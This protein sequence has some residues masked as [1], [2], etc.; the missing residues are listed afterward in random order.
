V[1]NEQL[2][3]HEVFGD[4]TEGSLVVL[5]RKAG[6]AEDVLREEYIET[7]ELP[8]DSDRKRM[9]VIVRNSRNKKIEAYVKG[10]PDLLLQRCDSYIE[11][12]KVK[13]LTPKERER[14]L[15]MNNA[16]AQ[17]ALRVLGFAYRDVSALRSYPMETVERNLVFVG[18]VGMIDPPRDEVPDAIRKCHEAGIKVMMITGDQAITAKAIAMRIGLWEPGSAMLSGDELEHMSDAELASKIESVRIVA[19]ALPV[20]KVRIV[21]ALK[22]HGHIVAMTGD[23]VNDAPALK[24]ADIGIAMG[25]GSDVAREV[26]KGTL[27]D[28]DFS[29]IVNAIEE[30]R[31]IYDKILK[32]ARYLLSCNAGEITAVFIALVMS[33]PLPLLPLQLLLMNILTDDVPALGLGTEPSDDGIMQRPPR[34]PKEHPIDGKMLI[35]I[36]VFGII[37]G[38]GTMYVFLQW[39]DVDLPRAQTMAFTTLVLIEM[40]AVISARSLYPSLRKLNP[41]SNLPLLSAVILSVAIQLVVIY[42]TPLQPIF[43]TVALTWAD[44]A[45]ILEV[46]VYGFIGMEISKIFLWLA[47]KRKVAIPLV[48]PVVAQ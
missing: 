19:R 43:G 29:S 30:G 28:D 14:I 11:N 27:V 15:R 41:F 18:L 1:K 13:R 5:G 48:A 39:K 22:K 45:L 38:L 24:R 23:G 36:V 33:F 35:S 40:F 47:S 3:R 46:S 4:P 8:F 44:W 2:G 21:D 10:A 16:F 32:S 9:T 25:S 31:N 37:M 7:M 20:Q 42:W 6:L 12:G 26:S 17:Q 34:D